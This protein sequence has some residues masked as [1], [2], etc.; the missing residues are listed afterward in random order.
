MYLLKQNGKGKGNGN[1]RGNGRGYG[2][3]Y[4]KPLT[5]AHLL[6]LAAVQPTCIY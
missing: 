6:Y 5:P 1:G 3:G 2:R 4:D